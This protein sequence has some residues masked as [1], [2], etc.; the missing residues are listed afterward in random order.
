MRRGMRAGRVG[1]VLVAVLLAGCP[2][3][4]PSGPLR[5]EVSGP[6]AAVPLVF[7]VARE[8]DTVHQVTCPGG[9]P[10]FTCEE[11]ALLVESASGR[12]EVTVKA[13]GFRF[14]VRSFALDELL[15]VDG[16]RMLALELPALEERVAN[17]DYTTGFGA[18]GLESFRAMAYP[19]DTELGPT[20]L[21]KF[22]IAGA[23]TDVPIVY[24]QNTR[25]HPLHYDFA[26]RVL[27]V[28]QTTSEFWATTYAGEDRTAMA[29]TLALYERV[30]AASESLGAE[31][32]APIAVTFFPSDD[33]TPAQARDA[34]QWIEERVDFAPL[35]GGGPQRVLYLP[36]GSDRERELLE[37]RGLFARR[38]EGWI[39]QA[40]LWGTTSLQILN[41]GEAY[42]TLR[43]LSPEELERVVVSY[44]DVLVLTGLPNDLPIVGGTITEQFQTPL[45]HVNLSAIA[46][47]TP[48]IAWLDAAADPRVRDNLGGIVH[49][50]VADGDF[51]L[52]PAT[53][54]EAQAFWDARHPEPV[55]LEAD[56]TPTGLRSFADLGFAD[57]VSVGVKAANL[58]ELR[59]VLGDTTPDG[60]A[61]PF[62]WYDG[63]MRASLV[64]P[65]ACDAAQAD[66]TTEGRDAALCAEARDVCAGFAGSFADYARALLVLESFR[67]RSELREALLD[68]LRHLI[69]HATL[70]PARAAQLDARVVEL[71]GSR[72]VRLRSSTNSEDLEDFTG[73]GLYDS[74]SAYGT[75][76]LDLA[77][78]EVRKVW[79]SVWNWAAFE[80]RSWWAIEHDTVYVGV[81]VHRAFGEEAANGVLITQNIADRMVVGMYANAQLGEVSVTNPEGGAIPE[82]FSIVPSDTPGR[83]QVV[84][85]SWSSLSPGSPIMTDAEIQALY[86]AAARVQT[87]FAPLYGL[88]PSLLAL[89]LEF[90][91]DAADRALIVKQV[92]PF[93]GY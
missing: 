47:G 65:A 5:I 75:G 31:V 73:A 15:A 8:D 30:T 64:T 28:S 56:L 3:S 19:S 51:V 90:K 25:R 70:D 7:V 41:E 76:V 33:L 18:D 9:A 79:A 26:R 34:V 91:L 42:G 55:T 57:S 85:L 93:A 78:Q 89:D 14:A 23:A 45:A 86:Q 80:E 37:H 35:V 84:R 69:R 92:R 10:G 32:A 29:G 77:S 43:R 27:H 21:V 60:F 66:C 58:A 50:V 59:G 81:A 4:G 13:R 38:G 46:R 52:E 2:S 87:H 24:F 16:V 39:R 68:G 12:L 72:K 22:Y 71:V 74:C 67:T 88:H 6:G 62:S 20:L 83:V 40:E 49:F 54:E 1:G 44:T 82:I 11:R 36:A 17:D 48:N 61:V 53:L 63:F